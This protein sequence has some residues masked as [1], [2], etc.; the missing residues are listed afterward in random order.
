[1]AESSI[2]T[3]GVKVVPDM[4]E[5]TKLV[6]AACHGLTVTETIRY[7]YDGEENLISEVKVTTFSYE[8]AQ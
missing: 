5:F 7:D 8:S 2:G 1:M 6:D 4:T 3:V